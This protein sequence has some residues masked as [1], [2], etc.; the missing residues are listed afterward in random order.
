MNISSL[1]LSQRNLR[2]CTTVFFLSSS[3]LRQTTEALW[4]FILRSSFPFWSH[5]TH[6]TCWGELSNKISKLSIQICARPTHLHIIQRDSSVFQTHSNRLTIWAPTYRSNAF[7]WTECYL[8]YEVIKIE[9]HCHRH[10][11]LHQ[12]NADRYRTNSQT[13]LNIK[14]IIIII[15]KL[16]MLLTRGCRP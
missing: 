10:S 9:A 6:Q 1:V 2:I 16:K 4:N 13:K 8:R 12:L 11:K 7:P 5:E 3:Q 14:I 15:I